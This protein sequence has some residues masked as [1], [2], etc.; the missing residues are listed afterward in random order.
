[1]IVDATGTRF[2]GREEVRRHYESGFA[3]IRIAAAICAPSPGIHDAA[4][5]SLFSAARGSGT[6][7]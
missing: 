4:W 6:G 5:L 1:M 3:V 2:E 7:K